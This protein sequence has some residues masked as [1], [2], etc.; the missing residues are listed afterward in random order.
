MT[1]FLT[2]CCCLFFSTN[3][4]GYLLAVTGDVWFDEL[5]AGVNFTHAIQIHALIQLISN[6]FSSLVL[7]QQTSVQEA[8]TCLVFYKE[9]K[10]QTPFLHPLEHAW[11]LYDCLK[12]KCAS[13]HIRGGESVFW[14]IAAKKKIPLTECA[15]YHAVASLSLSIPP[16]CW[17]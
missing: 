14:G 12:V 13:K 6:T 10:S 4:S 8:F 15:R 1:T 16:L 11:F 5:L 3:V 17:R 7:C 9:C 2:C